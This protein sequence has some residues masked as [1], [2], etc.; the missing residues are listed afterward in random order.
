MWLQAPIR[1]HPIRWQRFVRCPD[2]RVDRSTQRHPA[3][4]SQHESDRSD[5]D[6]PILAEPGKNRLTVPAHPDRSGNLDSAW[7]RN[8]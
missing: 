2:R 8:H 4:R 3:G 7:V 5:R 1:S 6:S